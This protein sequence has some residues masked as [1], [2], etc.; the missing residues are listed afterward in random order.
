MRAVPPIVG[1]GSIAEAGQ[2]R[3]LNHTAICGRVT[4]RCNRVCL[5]DW[6]RAK[7]L[8]ILA[9]TQSL[10]GQSREYTRMFGQIGIWQI[11][12]VAL[13][14]LVLFGRGRISEM[15]G[16]FGRGISSFKKGDER[17][18]QRQLIVQRPD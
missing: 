1:R 6:R 10:F 12:I 8:P 14:I 16:D 15:M 11:L 9:A 18:R 17:G 3:P 5:D 7:N 4:R 13:V 2:P